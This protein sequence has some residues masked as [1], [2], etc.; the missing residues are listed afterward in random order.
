MTPTPFHVARC[1][2]GLGIFAT[3]FIPRGATI[4][5]FRGPLVDVAAVLAKGDRSGDVVQ[6]DRHRYIDPDPP[7]LYVNHSCDP[8]AGIRDGSSLVAI[9]PIWPGEQIC[10]DYSTTMCD[11]LWSLACRCGSPHC[12]GTVLDFDLIPA[13]VAQRYL[14]LGIVQP[15][16]VRELGAE[17]AVPA[18]D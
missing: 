1:E 12:R 14:A 6:V 8:N 3:H 5:L 17:A 4:L 10:F 13:H 15:F 18:R 2:L 16:I 7:G 9:Q 11:R